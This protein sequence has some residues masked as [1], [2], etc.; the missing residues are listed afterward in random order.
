MNEKSAKSRSMWRIARSSAAA[1]PRIR[2]NLNIYI[3][4]NNDG[5]RRSRLGSLVRKSSLVQAEDIELTSRFSKGS[6]TSL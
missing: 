1:E 3:H 6:V 5:G 2:I 4:S